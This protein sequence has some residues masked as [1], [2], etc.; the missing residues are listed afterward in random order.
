MKRL[1]L[2]YCLLSFIHINHCADNQYRLET[3]M[4]GT[5][6]YEQTSIMELLC[7]D[8]KGYPRL[9]NKQVYI[10]EYWQ[11]L[12]N[13]S[14]QEKDDALIT[15]IGVYYEHGYTT[16]LNCRANIFSAITYSGARIDTKSE[17]SPLHIAAQ[18]N[19]IDLAKFLLANAPSAILQQKDRN[20]KTAIHSARSMQ[21]HELFIAYGVLKKP[22]ALKGL[23]NSLVKNNEASDKIIKHYRNL[24][25]IYRTLQ[26]N[27]ASPLS[28][29][30]DE[31]TPLL[32]LSYINSVFSSPSKKLFKKAHALFENLS[33]EETKKL[34]LWKNKHD[35]RTAF[36]IIQDNCNQENC[37]HEANK[38]K[39]NDAII[40]NL[41]YEKLAWAAEDCT[42]CS[43]K[44]TPENISFSRMCDHI[45]C[46]S[47]FSG[48]YNSDE[49]SC[50]ICP[51]CHHT[52]KKA[53]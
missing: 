51:K 34:L 49:K 45:Y 39:K 3:G 19:D 31:L 36:C 25:V 48:W 18:K 9:D 2:A 24:N 7:F 35:N 43:E 44:L 46:N 50:G 1:L 53:T 37:A 13:K 14:Q 41:F 29:N 16:Y 27:W 47:C 32:T 40:L 6:I 12:H 21:M 5:D 26:N 38:K 33:K 4:W 42:Q 8:P 10:T 28:T 22:T 30:D 15:A 23:L 52:I 17:L 11:Q 20:G